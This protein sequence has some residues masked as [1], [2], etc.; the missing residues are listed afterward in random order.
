VNIDAWY[1]R[2][3]SSNLSLRGFENWDKIEAS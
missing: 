3:A 1:I 2:A